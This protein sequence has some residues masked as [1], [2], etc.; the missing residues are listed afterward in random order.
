MGELQDSFFQFP[1]LTYHYCH[2]VKIQT[3]NSPNAD[4][5]NHPNEIFANGYIQKKVENIYFSGGKSFVF[6]LF[7]IIFSHGFFRI[8]KTNLKGRCVI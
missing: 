3:G 5:C 2:A 7:D 8:Q 4:A 6:H 1:H